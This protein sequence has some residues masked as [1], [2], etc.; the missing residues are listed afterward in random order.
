V[1][2]PDARTLAS[3]RKWASRRVFSIV[4]LLLRRDTT[5]GSASRGASAHRQVGICP[6][7]NGW[8]PL[9]LVIE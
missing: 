3:T 1:P 4:A 5:L 9:V 8:I 7:G 2:N 6:A